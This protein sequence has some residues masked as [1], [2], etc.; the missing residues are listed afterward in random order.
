MPLR[1]KGV[2]LWVPGLVACALWGAQA[3]PA[4]ADDQ[5]PAP[6]AKAE[7]A[8]APTMADLEKRIRELEAIVHRLEAERRQPAPASAA[9]P[10]TTQEPAAAAQPPAAEP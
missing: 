1:T 7:A 5:P 6:P 9:A 4:R 2:R 8:P 3:A 10:V